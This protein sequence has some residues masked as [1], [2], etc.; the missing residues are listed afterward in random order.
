MRVSDSMQTHNSVYHLNQ[1]AARLFRVQEQASTGLRFTLPSQ[2]PSGTVR[3]ANL[4]SS[5]SELDRY[6]ANADLAEARLKLTE[7]SVAHIGDSLREAR[8][9]ALAGGNDG[10]DETARKSM[11]EQVN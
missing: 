1:A 6:L 11:A 2:D 5:L 9:L 8:S 10:L 4:R 3:E 7:T